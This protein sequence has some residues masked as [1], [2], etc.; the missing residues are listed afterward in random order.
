MGIFE[1]YGFND[2]EF[3]KIQQMPKE[4][5]FLKAK[6]IGGFEPKRKWRYHP[7]FPFFPNQKPEANA[8]VKRAR[9]QT[10]L[11]EKLTKIRLEYFYRQTSGLFCGKE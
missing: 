11:F 9:K 6:W 7:H 8:A 3:V 5:S 1:S 4:A 2:T 10:I